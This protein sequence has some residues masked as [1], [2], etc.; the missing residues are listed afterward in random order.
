MTSTP[1]TVL[2]VFDLK[3]FTDASPA[4]RRVL[5]RTVDDALESVGFLALV[6]HGIDQSAID[7][8][9]STADTFFNLPDHLKSDLVPTTPGAPGFHPV[10]TGSLA[11][12]MGLKRSPD[13]KESFTVGPVDLPPARYSR[14]PEAM[15]WFPHNRWPEVE[16]MRESW[17]LYYR[18]ASAVSKRLMRVFEVSL[19]LREG[20]FTDG[21]QRE[22]SV[23]S[24][25]HYPPQPPSHFD[26]TRAGPHSD[27]STL[28]LFHKTEGADRLEILRDDGEWTAVV[29]PPGGLVVN[30]GDLMARWVDDRWVSRVHRVVG[31][32]PGPAGARG[33]SISIG[34]FHQP[35][36]DAL[37]QPP[38][39]PGQAG[40]AS[41]GVRAGAYLAAKMNRQHERAGV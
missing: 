14:R 26:R 33:G 6:G 39:A 16:R 25:V 31:P 32:T 24:A 34:F 29:A 1:D 10:E 37:I 23:L 9:R 18:Q 22:T 21:C 19:G 15:R 5:A 8:V 17:T 41:S 4:E 7:E 12:T 11:R 30:I 2:P 27:Y 38:L 40:S 36:Y 35:D 20:A 28:T 3:A 13:H